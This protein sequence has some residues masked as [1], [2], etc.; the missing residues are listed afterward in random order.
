M[1]DLVSTCKWIGNSP[2]MQPTCCKPTVEGRSY[3]EDHMWLV[4][5]KGSALGKRKK[6]ARRAQ[7]IWDIESEFNIAVEELIEEGEL[8]L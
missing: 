3:C 6:D 2:K 4:Y 8:D 1:N 7:A 5:Q